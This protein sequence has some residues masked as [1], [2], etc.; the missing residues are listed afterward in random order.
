MYHSK[1][2]LLLAGFMAFTTLPSCSLKP[3]RPEG[4]DKTA[5][6]RVNTIA[7]R[8]LAPE[9]TYNRLRWVHPPSMLPARDYDQK[10]SEFRPRILPVVR[11]EVE[12]TTLKE[13]ALILGTSTRYTTYCSS[14]VENERVSLNQLGT[15][16]EL[17]EEIE[18]RTP[19]DIVID[20]DNKAIR[21]LGLN[22][23]APQFSMQR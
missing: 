9:R 11:L 15:L 14:L 5:Q 1:K 12:N 3:P 23:V 20:H 2:L 13:V 17:A 16:D 22:H 21:F 18:N 19:V 10:V 6:V 8:Q 7:H 4:N